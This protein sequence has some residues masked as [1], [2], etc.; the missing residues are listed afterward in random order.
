VKDILA[1]DK[2]GSLFL[3]KTHEA[4]Y[5]RDSLLIR[6]KRDIVSNRIEISKPGV[7]VL[8]DGRTI[9]ITEEPYTEHTKKH[10]SIRFISFPMIIRSIK[11][12]DQFSPK[13][14]NGKKKTI[15]KYLVEE[16]LNRFQ[17]EQQLVIE[18]DKAV[19]LVLGQRVSHKFDPIKNQNIL[20]F[21]IVDK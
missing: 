11:P 7:Y 2:T 13:G 16:K 10:T 15:K 12:G 19:V 3:S 14:M 6:E 5:D 17:K 1:C 4:L 21:N 8:Q 20:S 9:E 18:K